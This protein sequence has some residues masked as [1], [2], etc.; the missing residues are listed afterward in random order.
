MAITSQTWTKYTIETNPDGPGNT[1]TSQ[2]MLDHLIAFFTANTGQW[3]ISSS[4][5]NYLE[6]KPPAGSINANDRILFWGGVEP[7]TGATYGSTQRAASYFYACYAPNAGTTGPDNLPSAGIPY[8]GV[9]SSLLQLCIHTFGSRDKLAVYQS[10]D[11]ICLYSGQDAATT[12]SNICF[13]GRAFNPVGTTDQFPMLAAQGDTPA[14]LWGSSLGTGV[15]NWTGDTSFAST[16]KRIVVQTETDGD[17][18]EVRRINSWV[19]NQYRNG[20]NEER[21][22]FNIRLGYNRSAL[23]DIAGTVLFAKGGA[24]NIHGTTIADGGG[25]LGYAQSTSETLDTSSTWYLWNE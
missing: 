24:S 4:G 8:T 15:C 10:N 9:N 17:W 3:T 7:I 11:C 2:T 16:D 22:F 25:T 5:A 14:A 1:Y 12:G 23:N 6:L 20:S 21:Y 19:N 18:L 13:I